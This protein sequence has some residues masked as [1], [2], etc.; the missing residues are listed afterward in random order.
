MRNNE[1]THEQR[2]KWI[3]TKNLLRQGIQI[4][5]EDVGPPPKENS[6]SASTSGV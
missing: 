6:A 4:D 1:L 3:A 2:Q 5:D